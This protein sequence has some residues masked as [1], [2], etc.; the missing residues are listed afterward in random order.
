MP[1]GQIAVL[2]MQVPEGL[3]RDL[4]EYRRFKGARSRS[5]VGREILQKALWEFKT[6]KASGKLVRD[7]GGQPGPLGE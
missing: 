6:Q 7:A 4:E 2:T 1:I 3:V 5:E